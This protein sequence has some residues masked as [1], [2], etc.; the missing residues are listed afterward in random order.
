MIKGGAERL[1]DDVA[2]D[3]RRSLSR[4]L[5]LIWIM[6]AGLA[7]VSQPELLPRFRIK[8]EVIARQFLPLRNVS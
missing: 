8:G 6:P 2:R 7:L 4:L 3:A 1:W 5:N